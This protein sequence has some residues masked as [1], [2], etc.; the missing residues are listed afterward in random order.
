MHIF[1]KQ[2]TN[3]VRK[4]FEFA[5]AKYSFSLKTTLSRYLSQSKKIV[6]SN[7][8]HSCNTCKQADIVHIFSIACIVEEFTNIYQK[9]NSSLMNV[10]S[11]SFHLWCYVIWHNPTLSI[12][13]PAMFL[14]GFLSIQYTFI[15][16]MHGSP[17]SPLIFMWRIPVL[18]QLKL[19]LYF[20]SI[21][22]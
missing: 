21:C 4:L 13:N 18:P 11:Y 15:M 9:S 14:Y 1:R 16:I 19:Y 6:V 10:Y 8:V 5:S 3:G 20:L 2:F 12:S 17:V 22:G 7:K